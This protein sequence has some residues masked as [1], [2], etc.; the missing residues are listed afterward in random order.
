MD[1]EFCKKIEPKEFLGMAWTKKDKEQRSPNL[2]HFIGRFN[3][4]SKWI[5]LS[6]CSEPN[7]KKRAKIVSQIVDIVKSLK[8]LNNFNGIFQIVGGLGNASVYRLT[9]TF[10]AIKDRKKD[11]EALRFLTK[12]EKS[13]AN[14][15]RELHGINPPCIPFLG[16]YQTDLTFIEDGNPD[17][18][19]TGL[20]NFKKCR[21]T[22]SVMSEI[23]QYQQKPY[24]LQICQPVLNWLMQSQEQARYTDDKK[25][26]EFS[27]EAEPREQTRE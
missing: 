14:Y 1:Y 9:K 21:L 18:F 20:W 4:V 2:L 6:V 23:Q 13:W 12:P 26:Y 15:R 16:I 22:A 24:N 5:A 19:S 3:M 27:L 11:L 17:K 7:L 25:L 10:E 8:D